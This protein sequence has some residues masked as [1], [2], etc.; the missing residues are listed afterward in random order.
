MRKTL[1]L[2]TLFLCT[3]GSLL[4]QRTITG[5]VTDEKGDPIP[6]A[7]VTVKGTTTGSATKDDG[8]YALTVPASAKELV[9]SSVD[10][11]SLTIAIGSSSVI[12]VTLKSLSDELTDVVITGYT[13]ERRRDFVGA[14]AK[15]ESKA[16][17]Q[18]PNGSIDQLL[19]GRAPGLYVTAG[20][21]QPGTAANVIIRGVGSISGSSTPLYIMDGI[22]IQAAAFASL[23][24]SDIETV[25]VLRDA[26]ATAMYGSRGANGVIVITTKRGKT[27]SKVVFGI[28][29][30]YGVS[31]RTRP[32]FEM[33]DSKQRIQ[34]EEEVG[35]ENGV[36]IGPGWRFSRFNPSNAS[37]P[38]ATLERYDAIRDSLAG[39]NIDWTD[40]FFRQGS[41]QQHQFTATGGSEKLSFYT[42]LD[43]YKQEGIAIRS[44]LERYSFRTNLD[45]KTDKFTA[46]LSTT[47]NYSQSSIIESENTTAVTNPFASIYYALPYE[48]PYINGVL[49]AANNSAFFGN[50]V[51][52]D[53]REGSTALER[54]MSTTNKSNEI[55]G[56]V[57][58]NLRYKL[59]DGLSIVSTS[60]IDYR[61]VMG[62]RQILPGTYTGGQVAGGQGS[63][64][65]SVGRFVRLF[66]N[67]G[68][69]YNK[70]IS[71]R[72]SIDLN[73]I[74]ETTKSTTRNFNY[75]GF[76][77]EPLLQ[78]S[79]AG[80]TPGSVVNGQGRFIPTVGGSGSIH[81]LQSLVVVGKYIL[82]DKYILNASYRYD[83][84][85]S[86]PLANRWK[87]FY[88]VGAGWNAG[89]EDFIKNINW[90]SD[91]SVRASYG[92]TA[93]PIT[94]FGYMALYGATRYAGT[95]G[96]G[97][98]NINNES[99]DWEYAKTLNIGVDYGFFKNRIRGSVDFYN[100]LTENLF[101]DQRLSATAGI[102]SLSINAGTLKN[103][104]WEFVLAGDVVR[105]RD[106]TWTVGGNISFN[107]NEITDLGQVNEFI[108]GTSIIR[109][110]LPMGTHYL[111]KWAGVDA[112]T[113][114]PLYYNLDGTVTTNYDRTAQS[115]VGYGSWLPK[116]NGGINSTLTYKGIGLDIFFSYAGG[117]KRFNNEDYFNQVPNFATSNQGT[118]ML[119]RWR[120]PGDVTDIQ[121]FGTARQFSSKD[122]Q[123]ASYLRLRNVNLS[124]TIPQ[125]LLERVKGITNIRVYLQGQN[126]L[127]WTRW[128][129]FD[130][131]DNNN[132]AQFE[133]PAARTIT[134]G[135]SLNF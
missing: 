63:F 62:R 74:F 106:L 88:S 8:T 110:G 97:L 100:K 40:I 20:S 36:N 116:Y 17:N 23:S 31:N 49:V 71:K 38:E 11:E 4:A 47:L 34:Y 52:Y 13:R 96:F 131:E 129:S 10:F 94:G 51:T 29:S 43:Y 45:F 92:L 35:R 42:S 1:M 78:N 87:S 91:L 99:Y 76:G 28:N 16:I 108:L 134:A 84:T 39:M 15:V 25:D 107:K 9:F 130:P 75:T 79:P 120:K 68:F 126:L 89:R 70:L 24:S 82:D 135:I 109:V 64:G 66:G 37:L 6:S 111:P 44:N 61:E 125:S 80:I 101:I 53:Q 12:N 33:M 114:N 85:S 60:G 57:G 30:Q 104:G 90:I 105:K 32:K 58:L 98:T 95:T 103:T 56:V 7:S 115:N 14:S 55:K 22:P 118:A 102:G 48:Q 113:G 86:M 121:K 128:T 46:S 5:K 93:S 72:H 133:Y 19:Q 73:A 41:F 65:E 132:I 59:F 3:A 67:A 123:D 81:A 2:L 124:Y 127:T 77:I 69:N 50:V 117:N 54:L 119:R 112:A 83:G 122:I 27:N 26:S 21:G 18:V